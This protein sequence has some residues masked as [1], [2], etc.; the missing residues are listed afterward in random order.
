MNIATSLIW[1]CEGN[2]IDLFHK[3]SRAILQISQHIIY[4]LQVEFTLHRLI[5]YIK[6][7]IEDHLNILLYEFLSKLVIVC[8]INYIKALYLK[9]EVTSWR[10][11]LWP[12]VHN[13]NAT[14]YCRC[15]G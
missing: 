8:F 3:N 12:L 14:W 15:T 13:P 4:S 5:T 10:N 11:Y 2:H 6:I 9:C 1:Y 7:R